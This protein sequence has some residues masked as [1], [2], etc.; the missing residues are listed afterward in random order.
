MLE[1]N[2]I[3]NLN[4]DNNVDKEI[5]LQL[6]SKNNNNY[7][8]N[9]N[10]LSK[11]LFKIAFRSNLESQSFEDLIKECQLRKKKFIDREFPPIQTSLIN[12][13]CSLNIRYFL[14]VIM[15]TPWSSDVSITP[16]LLNVAR[17]ALTLHSV[18]FHRAARNLTDAGHCA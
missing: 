4:E 5:L 16:R 12:S 6:F 3:N 11:L 18:H 13:S 7:K 9:I 14:M 1:N 8:K 10:I 17:N 2:N 15:F